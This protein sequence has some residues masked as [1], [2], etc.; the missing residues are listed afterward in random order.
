MEITITEEK[1]Q[2][3]NDQHYLMGQR[4]ALLNQMRNSLREMGYNE[5]FTKERMIMERE[6]AINALRS[7]CMEHGDNDWNEDLHMADIINKHLGNYLEAPKPESKPTKE[8]L[9]KFLTWMVEEWSPNKL[10]IPFMDS[11]AD[12]YIKLHLK[13]KK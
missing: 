10:I 6:D 5:E 12:D 3:L 4:A 9:N 8:Q 7:I 1:L 2:E 11:A 13:P